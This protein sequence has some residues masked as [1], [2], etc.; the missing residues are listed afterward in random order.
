MEFTTRTL[1]FAWHLTSIAWFGLAAILVPLSHPPVTSGLLGYVMGWTFMVTSA[2]ILIGSRGRH[3][4][5]PLFLGVALTAFY[6]AAK[7]E[8]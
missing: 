2:A 4:A 1:R 7:L 8:T 5:W 3:L 6:G